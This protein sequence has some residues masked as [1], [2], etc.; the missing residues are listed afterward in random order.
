MDERIEKAFEVANYM[1]TL[2][3]QRRILAEEYNQKLIYYTNGATFLITP[4][5]ITFTKTMIDL[6]HTVDSP[7]IDS[8]N[9][10]VLINDVEA[11]FKD[12]TDRYFQALNDYAF[13]YA[14]IKSKR[15]VSDIVEL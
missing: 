6:G 15:K 2:A 12:I 14:K 3:N 7:F 10:P 4:D 5:L 13:G 1:A 9:C 8:N 11:F